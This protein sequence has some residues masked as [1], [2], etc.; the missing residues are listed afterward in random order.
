MGQVESESLQEVLTLTKS[1][2]RFDQ[3][4]NINDVDLTESCWRV[5]D[6]LVGLLVVDGRRLHLDGVVAVT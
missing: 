5:N 3:F 4:K 6:D 1:L 2:F